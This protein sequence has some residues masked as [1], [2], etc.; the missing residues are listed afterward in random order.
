[1]RSL[2]RLAAGL[3]AAAAVL[4]V[5]LAAE[6]GEAGAEKPDALRL[7]I[8]ANSDSEADQR[9][10]LKVRDALLEVFGEGEVPE[11]RREAYARLIELGPR[12]QETAE[13]VLRENGSDD[14]VTL[15]AGEFE[16]PER[17]YGG[18]VYP[19]GRYT[20]LRVMI[21]AGEGHN[22]WCVMFPPL[23][24][25]DDGTGVETNADGTLRFRS[26]FAELFG[27]LFG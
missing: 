12:L 24:L 14:S 27:R 13:R 9:V 21:G 18:E 10:K 5:L 1:M 3:L 15:E 6:K 16:F 26:F 25:I 4:G 2:T 7:H 11:D 17:V 22:W 23:C 8:L 20:A 19:A